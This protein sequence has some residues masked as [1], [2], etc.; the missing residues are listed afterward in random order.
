[1]IKKEYREQLGNEEDTFFREHLINMID[2]EIVNPSREGEIGLA[3][4]IIGLRKILEEAKEGLECY[5]E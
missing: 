2:E 1:M 4:F 3:G 5:P